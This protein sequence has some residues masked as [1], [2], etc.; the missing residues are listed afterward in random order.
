MWDRHFITL[1]GACDLLALEH[2][3]AFWTYFT[4]TRLPKTLLILPRRTNVCQKHQLSP[5]LG[6]PTMRK[7]QK[8][9]TKHD[10]IFVIQGLGKV[11]TKGEPC[12]TNASG[13][14]SDLLH[15]WHWGRWIQFMTDN[16]GQNLEKSLR[17]SQAACQIWERY[18]LTPVLVINIHKIALKLIKFTICILQN[19]TFWTLVPILASLPLPSPELPALEDLE[20]SENPAHFQLWQQ[21]RLV[22]CEMYFFQ[23]IDIFFS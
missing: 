20:N 21:F 3:T 13:E 4:S 5:V 7:L 14:I 8:S 6:L 12:Q 19:I 15:P 18:T 2:F 10:Q 23:Q 17:K 22:S 1:T 11:Y 16:L 9:N